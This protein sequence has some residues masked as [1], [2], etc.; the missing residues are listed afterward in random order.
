MINCDFIKRGHVQIE[1][2]VQYGRCV[3][4]RNYLWIVISSFFH[5]DLKIDQTEQRT[6]SD[7]GGYFITFYQW[8]Q[9]QLD[10]GD[11]YPGL[12]NLAIEF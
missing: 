11:A 3:S 8:K 12:L 2:L 4:K 1:L 5:V 9:Q 7:T 6:V 10:Y